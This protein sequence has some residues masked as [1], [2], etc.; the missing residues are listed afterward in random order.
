LNITA[1]AFIWDKIPDIIES[2]N[3]FT[4]VSHHQ[5]TEVFY[6]EQ[7]FYKMQMLDGEVLSSGID[8]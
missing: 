4:K 7:Q 3:M 8:P 2:G 6:Q 5:V 1:K